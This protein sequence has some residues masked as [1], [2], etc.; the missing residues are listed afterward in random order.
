MR[1]DRKKDFPLLRDN[2]IVYLDTAATS[3]KPEC[4]LKA[5]SEF[6]EKYNANPFRGIHGLGEMATEQ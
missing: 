3:Q 4:V 5:E 6:Y 2:S 1:A